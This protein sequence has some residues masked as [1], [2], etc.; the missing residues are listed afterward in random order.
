MTAIVAANA[1]PRAVAA[2][3]ADS[4]Q[5]LTLSVAGQSFG[6]PALRV[7]DVLG[8]QRIARVPLAPREVAGTLNLRGRVVTAIDLRLCLQ[9]PPRPADQKPMS[10]VV[11]PGGELYS[12][13]VDQVGEVLTLSAATFE[14]SPATLPA[15]WRERS[16]GIHRLDGQLLVLLD[17]DRLLVF[18]HPHAA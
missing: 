15:R 13:L 16:T 4:T 11:D 6:I 18:A 9:Q 8:P 1:S 12:L 2:A 14:P 7:H 3:P 5:V 17:I 10:I